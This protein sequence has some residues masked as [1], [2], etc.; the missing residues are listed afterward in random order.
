MIAQYLMRTVLFMS[1]PE[2]AI[3]TK[4]RHHTTALN[5]IAKIDRERKT[6]AELDSL[7]VALNKRLKERFGK[8]IA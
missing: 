7:I 2:I 6:D 1:L 8:E 3:A 4:R 5:A